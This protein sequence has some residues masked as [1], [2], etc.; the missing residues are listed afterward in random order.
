MS[1]G[2]GIAV[3]G[4]WTG[5]AAS[6]YFI[7]PLGIFVALFAMIATGAVSDSN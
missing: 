5:V 2:S 4:I 1:I 3:I 6:C 7:G